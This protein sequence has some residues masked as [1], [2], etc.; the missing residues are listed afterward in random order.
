MKIIITGG[1][2]T[3]AVA[4]IEYIKANT[5]KDEVYLFGRNYS[6]SNKK[7][8]AIEKQLADELAVPFIAIEVP[9]YISLLPWHVL[10]YI[11]QYCVATFQALRYLVRIKPNVVVSFGGYYAVPIVLMAWVLKIPIVTHEQTATAGRANRFIG[12]FAKKIAIS[13]ES[14]TYLFPGKKTV[15]TGNPIRPDLL[16]PKPKQPTWFTN[17]SKKP[18]IYITGGNQGSHIINTVTKNILRHLTRDFVVI[19]ACGRPTNT[20][21]YFQ[22]LQQTARSLPSTHQNRY[23]IREWISSQE[24][25]WIL[26]NAQLTISRAGANTIQELIL[27]SMPALLIPL[28]FS[29]NNEQALNAKIMTDAGGAITLAQKDFT[30]EVALQTIRDMLA[31][32]KSYK[33]K[34]ELVVL[35]TDASKKLYQVVKTVAKKTK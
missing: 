33:R 16:D 20:E 18:I 32:H 26:R 23:F 34:L 4:F 30:P 2:I 35:P 19:H 14:G 12:I 11:Y 29:F 1:H 3:P 7:Q 10:Q 8:I 13:F 17:T 27:T 25:A 22:E 21:N 31:K 6:Q 28:P 15:I 5:P 9:K 24:L